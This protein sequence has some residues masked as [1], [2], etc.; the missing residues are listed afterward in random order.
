M[1]S[2]GETSVKICYWLPGFPF[3][4]PCQRKPSSMETPYGSKANAAPCLTSIN[5]SLWRKTGQG[6]RVSEAWNLVDRTKVRVI[7]GPALLSENQLLI[8]SKKA[9]GPFNWCALCL[10]AVRSMTGRGNGWR[11]LNDSDMR[12][13][14][15]P[16]P[17]D[18]AQTPAT[19]GSR[20]DV[21]F[22]VN[23]VPLFFLLAD[24]WRILKAVPPAALSS[25][26]K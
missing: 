16:D 2:P 20:T 15:A 11:P 6:S 17:A 13:T 12:S 25:S 8:K 22:G 24:L 9:T 26:N 4:S 1:S 18:S 3:K 7:M 14:S 19:K 23:S 5:L 21:L 10:P